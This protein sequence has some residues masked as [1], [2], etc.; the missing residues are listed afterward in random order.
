MSDKNIPDYLERVIVEYAELKAKVSLL[1]KMLAG[2]QPKFVSDTQWALLNEQ[3]T[4]MTNYQ[5]VLY[6]RITDSLRAL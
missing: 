2:E 3:H 1:A 5:T 4:H 6:Q